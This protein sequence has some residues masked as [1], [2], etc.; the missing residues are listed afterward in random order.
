MPVLRTPAFLPLLG[1]TLGLFR[2]PRRGLSDPALLPRIER[3]LAGATLDPAWLAAYRGSVGLS[4]GA[5]LPPLALQLAA[6]PACTWPSSATHSS[7]FARWG[8]CTCRSA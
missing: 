6:A 8:W 4:D 3:A 7:R 2:H 5:R 1:S